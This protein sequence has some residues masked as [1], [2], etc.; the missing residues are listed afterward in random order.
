MPDDLRPKRAGAA[1]SEPGMT[2]LETFV[3]AAFAFAATMLVLNTERIPVSFGELVETLKGVPAFAASIATLALFWASHRELT[4]R[5]PREDGLTVILSMALIGV[6]LV[7]VYPLKFA[8]TQ[9]FAY[10]IPALRTADFGKGIQGPS[11]LAG[12]FMVYGAGFGAFHLVLM[13]LFRH[14]IKITGALAPAERIRG[15]GSVQ[16]H[17]YCALVAGLS[18]GVASQVGSAR[19]IL[20][21]TIP[22]FVYCILG[23]LMPVHWSKV[24]RRAKAAEASLVPPAPGG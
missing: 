4:R 6:A 12:M 18:V 11:D 1:E 19:T 10:F 16:A 3:D 14:Q 8:F 9:G 20:A 24:E 15:Q 13:L 22:G 7:F 2:R 17:L 21:A 5:F 23:V